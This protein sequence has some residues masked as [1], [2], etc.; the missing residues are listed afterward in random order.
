MFTVVYSSASIVAEGPGLL[1]WQETQVLY[2]PCDCRFI[3][4]HFFLRNQPGGCKASSK[5]PGSILLYQVKSG[6]PRGDPSLCCCPVMSHDHNWSGY[7]F[8]LL[9]YGAV[10]KVHFHTSCSFSF[11]SLCRHL[12]FIEQTKAERGEG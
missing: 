5:C 11:H 6:S 4:F 2:L 3:C 10:G 1:A 9:S 12:H 8:L 7:I